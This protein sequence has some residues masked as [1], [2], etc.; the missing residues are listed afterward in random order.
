MSSWS[1]L[2]KPEWVLE[3]R[4]RRHERG[5]VIESVP[6]VHPY[7]SCMPSLAL[8]TNTGT[9]VPDRLTILMDIGSNIN[10]CGLKTAQDFETKCAL[11]GLTIKKSNIKPALYVSGVG[12]GAAVCNT[13]GEFPI[14][15]AW[16]RGPQ[17]GQPASS[18]AGQPAQTDLQTFTAAIAE[19]SGEG[20]PAI[21]GRRQ[22]ANERGIIILEENKEKYIN[23]GTADYKIMLTK[24]AKVVDLKHTPSGHLCMEVD[25]YIHA[26]ARNSNSCYTLH[27]IHGEPQSLEEHEHELDWI[28]AAKAAEV[29]TMRQQQH[30]ELEDQRVTDAAQAAEGRYPHT[31]MMNWNTDYLDGK[32]NDTW[33]NDEQQKYMLN[34][35][36]IVNDCLVTW[37]EPETSGYTPP[38]DG[39]VDRATRHIQAKVYQAIQREIDTQKEALRANWPRAPTKETPERFD[40]SSAA[41]DNE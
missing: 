26:S 34:M 17:A 4:R 12:S 38:S 10:I 37:F 32:I 25:D 19:G 14:G 30:A 24:G 33:T 21:M 41:G 23:V 27:A 1:H 3:Q 20:L 40:I 16:K 8:A 29:A 6:G 36:Q 13:T 39:D 7:Q 9:V 15:V 35:N 22:M 2:N 31:Y 18:T 11:H 28:T 5:T